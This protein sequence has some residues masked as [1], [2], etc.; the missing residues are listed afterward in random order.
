MKRTYE[1]VIGLEVHVQLDTRTKV[2]CSCRTA[3]GAV[4]NSNVC[5]V[6]LG[7]PGVLPVLNRKAFEYAVRVAFALGCDIQDTIKFDRK[8]YYYPDLPKNYQISQYDMPIAY[9]GAI[10]ICL[11]EGG[12]RK[13]GVKR[14]HLEEDAG[15][16]LHDRDPEFSYVDLNRTGTPLLEIVSE[17]EISSPEQAYKYLVT[18]K[19]II[20]YLGVSDCNMEE[21]SLRCDA[22]V[23]LREKGEDA[24][25]T[26]AEIKNLNS[27]KAVREALEYEVERQ[28]D[29]LNENGTVTHETRLW[30]EKARMTVS[31][32][33]K[34]MAQDYRYFP[35]PDLVPF[36][37][38]RSALEEIRRELPELPQERERRFRQS[39]DL[40]DHDIGVVLADREFAD[41]FE[42]VA[43]LCGSP[44]EACNWMTGEVLKNMNEREAE[45]G[46]LGLTP[47]SLSEIISMVSQSRISRLVAKDVLVECIESRRGPEDIVKEKG[48]EQVSDTSELESIIDRVVAENRK[49]VDDFR[50]GKQNALSY[51]IGQVMRATRG[52]ANPKVAGEMLRERIQS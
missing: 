46:S 27:F 9:D 25:G 19:Q 13:I 7:L 22:N 4:P 43:A 31:M 16:L 52:K 24:L 3:F 38:D 1:T 45:I 39:Y 21:G 20:K 15:K 35:D 5:P 47:D 48:L 51:L 42:A 29:L 11:P 37:V 34:E 23:S 14:A 28:A 10:S 41:F 26:K 12:T 33:S 32:R 50:G 44:R 17:P 40:E 36:E 8:N 18:L 49:T 6:C 2:F 30:D